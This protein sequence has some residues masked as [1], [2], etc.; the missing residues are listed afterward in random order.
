MCNFQPFHVNFIQV[1]DLYISL[2]VVYSTTLV[3]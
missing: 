2:K 1:D 3:V